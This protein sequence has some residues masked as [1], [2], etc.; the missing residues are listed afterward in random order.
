MIYDLNAGAPFVPMTAKMLTKLSDGVAQFVAQQT[1]H[2]TVIGMAGGALLTLAT[3][4][5]LDAIA[6]GLRRRRA[7]SES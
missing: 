2:A 4:L 7:R 5:T 1:A 3:L 6:W